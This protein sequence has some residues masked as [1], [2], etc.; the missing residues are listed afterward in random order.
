MVGLGDGG[1]GGG[2]GC[3]GD[4]WLDDIVCLLVLRVWWDYLKGS[5]CG[6][7]EWVYKRVVL[8]VGCEILTVWSKLISYDYHEIYNYYVINLDV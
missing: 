4:G 3:G 5:V 1:G 6:L 7:K 8:C 2:G